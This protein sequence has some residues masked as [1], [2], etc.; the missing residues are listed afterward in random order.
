[1]IKV[2]IV[3]ETTDSEAPDCVAA[4]LTYAG[5]NGEVRLDFECFVSPFV[6]G[7]YSGPPENCYPDEGPECE[8]DKVEVVVYKT[9]ERR[10]DR[11][12]QKVVELSNDIQVL[13]ME[14]F[15]EEVEEQAYKILDGEREAAEIAA[16]ESRREDDRYHG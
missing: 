4:L 13:L 16:Y 9:L 2:T 12:N 14:Y 1:M 11:E 10:R 7:Q 3:V 5:E 8:I 6:P 15:A